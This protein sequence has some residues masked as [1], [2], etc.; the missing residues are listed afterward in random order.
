MTFRQMI[1]F[2]ELASD[3]AITL[4]R[5]AAR[6][7]PWAEL[8]YPA[9]DLPGPADP[10]PRTSSAPVRLNTTVTEFMNGRSFPDANEIANVV[11]SSAH[12]P[13]IGSALNPGNKKV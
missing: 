12:S 5:T 1:N 11:S 7:D 2:G 8:G 6:G 10:S 3:Y 4:A 13:V 9:R